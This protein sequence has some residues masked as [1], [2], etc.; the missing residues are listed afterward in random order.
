[1]DLRPRKPRNYLPPV[2]KLAS[3]RRKSR[4]PKK[5]RG[6]E[7]FLYLI[8]GEFK[9]EPFWK[10]GRSVNA[11]RRFGQHEAQ[12]QGVEWKLFRFWKVEH[13]LSAE[14]A[15]HNKLRNLGFT[16]S[17]IVCSCGRLHSERFCLPGSSLDDAW[18]LA[19]YAVTRCLK[20]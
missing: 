20:I 7:A 14:L 1:M 15:A 3:Q 5:K 6:S 8:E 10:V 12:C 4:K 19:E 2:L 18:L 16:Q 17:E 11:I 13:Q 9:G